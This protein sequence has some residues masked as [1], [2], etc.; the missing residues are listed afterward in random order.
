MQFLRP[1]LAKIKLMCQQAA[2]SE[3]VWTKPASSEVQER[4]DGGISKVELSHKMFS[5][6]TQ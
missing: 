2:M 4:M 5:W 3:W 1:I 6:K